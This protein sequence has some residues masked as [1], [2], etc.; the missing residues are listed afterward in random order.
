M[1]VIFFIQE[2]ISLH[3]ELAHGMVLLHSFHYPPGVPSKIL[4]SVGTRPLYVIND[5]ARLLE[6]QGRTRLGR[7]GATDLCEIFC[8]NSLV[9]SFHLSDC[10]AFKINYIQSSKRLR[11]SLLM[12]KVGQRTINNCLG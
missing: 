1:I 11:T 9:L 5:P 7:G 2:W 4:I 12:R 8:N 10:E 6:E 3:N